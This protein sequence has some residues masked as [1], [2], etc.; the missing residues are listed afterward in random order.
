MRFVLQ[1]LESC[2]NRARGRLVDSGQFPEGYLVSA[3]TAR[4]RT[5]SAAHRQVNFRLCAG[6]AWARATVN[7][8]ELLERHVRHTDKLTSLQEV[9][10]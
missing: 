5:L 10:G 6:T 8:K 2:D 7:P 4:Q 9:T 1:M 3:G